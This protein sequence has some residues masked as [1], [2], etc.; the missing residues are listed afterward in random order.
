MNA[1]KEKNFRDS[2]KLPQV[3]EKVCNENETRKQTRKNDMHV[4]M[5]LMRRREFI[6]HMWK[7]SMIDYKVTHVYIALE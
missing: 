1:Q 4:K 3:H 2:R 6:G 7:S 5:L